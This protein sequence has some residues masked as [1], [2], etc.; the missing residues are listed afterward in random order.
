MYSKLYDEQYYSEQIEKLIII[1]EDRWD[2]NQIRLNNRAHKNN[3]TRNQNAPTK[4]RVLLSGLVY[5]GHCGTK[6]GVW[7]NHKHYA[8]AKGEMIKTIYDTYKCRGKIYS[9]EKKCDGQTTYS[10]KKIDT[11]VE[12]QVKL[13]ILELSKNKLS[14]TYQKQLDNSI[15]SIQ[16]EIDKKIK[17]IEDSEKQVEV[18]KNEVPKALLGESKFNAD[19]LQ[20]L[21]K[22]REEE[23]K[24]IKQEIIS[25]N[26]KLENEKQV[27][28]GYV[29][30]NKSL[31]SWNE[32]YDN[33]SFEKKKALLYEVIERVNIYK[34]TSDIT[35]KI[36]SNSYKTI[37][38]SVSV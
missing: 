14:K 35:F 29:K 8:N 33:A 22:E 38:G 21:L 3:N 15:K 30:V 2:L 10:A 1:P 37:L 27:R 24:V 26:D 34:D 12:E 18:L 13:F 9:K 25:L 17:Q 32:V 36:N 4:S 11:E 16:T 23:V 31:D 20:E 5:C 6:M 19:L 28:S 7:A